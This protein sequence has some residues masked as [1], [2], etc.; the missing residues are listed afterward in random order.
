MRELFGDRAEEVRIDQS[1]D[2]FIICLI[3][4]LTVRSIYYLFGQFIDCL[5]FWSIYQLSDCLI[6]LL[7]VWLSD[8]FIILWSI[9]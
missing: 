6:N 8:Q 3:N 2:Q 1:S 5:I 7:I 4:V 9:V